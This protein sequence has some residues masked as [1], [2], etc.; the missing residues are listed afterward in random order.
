[1][2][3]PAR[4]Q[5]AQLRSKPCRNSAGAS[6][7][8][9]E[10]TIVLS[11]V[12]NLAHEAGRNASDRTT[13]L[14]RRSQPQASPATKNSRQKMKVLPTIEMREAWMQQRRIMAVA[15]RS[16]SRGKQEKTWGRVFANVE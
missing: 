5:Q 15:V 6:G 11:C 3:V 16:L 10:E 14:C 1:M 7:T 8:C 2:Q 4:Q 12:G 9:A 13:F